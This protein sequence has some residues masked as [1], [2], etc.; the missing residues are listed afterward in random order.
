MAGDNPVS[1]IYSVRNG[2]AKKIFELSNLKVN[3]KPCTTD[4]FPRPAKRPK[5]SVMD[6]GNIC[7]NWKHPQS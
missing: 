5:Y 4:E 2:F 6:N 1:Q 7:R 3:L